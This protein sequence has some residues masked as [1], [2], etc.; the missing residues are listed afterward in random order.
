[1]SGSVTP[2]FPQQGGR[3]PDP[4]EAAPEAAPVR[5]VP[6]LRLE[7]V[8][9]LFG[10]P[11]QIR[12][13]LQA[14]NRDAAGDRFSLQRD[15][16]VFAAV[17][18]IALEVRRHEILA[19]VG[20]SGSGKSTLV[21]HM[22]GLIRPDHGRVLVDGYSLDSLSAREL[23]HLRSTQIGMVSQSTSLFAHRNVI[24]NVV[25]GLEV[26]RL[27]HK[28]RY[29]IAREWLERVELSAWAQHFPSELS[30][31][32]QQRVGLARTFATDP[33]TL[34]LDEPFSA[35]DPIIR[36]SLQDEFVSLVRTYRKTAVFITHDFTEAV[37]I[38][39]RIGVMVDGS[40]VQIG[41]PGH[42]ITRPATPY[43]ASFATPELKRGLATAATIA[44]PQ[45]AR[46]PRLLVAAPCLPGAT[47]LAEIIARLQAQDLNFHVVGDDG[48]SVGW[49]DRSVSARLS[50][51][52]SGQELPN[53]GSNPPLNAIGKGRA[54]TSSKLSRKCRR[55]YCLRRP[56]ALI[57]YV[58]AACA[59][60]FEV[61]QRGRSSGV[62]SPTYG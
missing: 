25:F 18:D 17:A 14:L 22:N 26:R 60:P 51:G 56:G 34:L 8:W 28:D 23:Q 16:R 10:A 54:K 61:R 20:A 33:E 62:P 37:R 47:P 27:P 32:M 5:P 6:A 9:K 13:A 35:L 49:I 12:R 11:R 45:T 39:D 38:A 15:H 59:A 44:A 53:P 30:G 57:R 48:R 24:D 43:V 2:L 3:V 52:Q 1:M 46:S 7:G 19:I 55:P 40:I 31:G 36:R 21:R 50:G 4:P 42:I 29:K 41:T 58:G